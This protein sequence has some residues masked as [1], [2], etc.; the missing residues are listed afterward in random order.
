MNKNT[1]RSATLRAGCL[2]PSE[3]RAESRVGRMLSQAA[4]IRI[5]REL[6]Q[7]VK[8]EPDGLF[9]R[10]HGFREFAIQR[11][12]APE[13]VMNHRIIGPQQRQ[14]EINL[15]AFRILPPRGVIIAENFPSLDV[16]GITPNDTFHEGDFDVEIPPLPGGQLFGRTFFSG[17]TAKACFFTINSKSSAQRD[18]KSPTKKRISTGNT[19]NKRNQSP[20]AYFACFAVLFVF[21][22]GMVLERTNIG[23]GLDLI[24]NQQ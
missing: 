1:R 24:R 9:Q 8:A 16:I 22:I 7:V 21:H 4:Q 10:R 19:R 12:A 11:V 23:G 2:Y 6:A 14:A 18:P 5:P 20:L 15:E 3:F 13:V 17:H